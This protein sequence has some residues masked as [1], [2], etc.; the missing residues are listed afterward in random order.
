MASEFSKATIKKQQRKAKKQA[1]RVNSE[2]LERFDSLPWNQAL[3]DSD[4]AFP[5]LV[6]SNELEGGA[7][8]SPFS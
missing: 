8:S 5:L 1:L 3:S 4:D 7:C 2:Q 6:G